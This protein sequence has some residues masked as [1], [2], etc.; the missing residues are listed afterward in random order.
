MR[1]KIRLKK[2]EGK[3]SIDGRSQK[4]ESSRVWDLEKEHIQEIMKSKQMVQVD[5]SITRKEDQGALC[6]QYVRLLMWVLVGGIMGRGE[7]VNQVLILSKKIEA[8]L[9]PDWRKVLGKRMVW[10]SKEERL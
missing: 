10:N 5:V 6:P 9:L 7:A 3:D 2:H 4:E 1:V 8:S